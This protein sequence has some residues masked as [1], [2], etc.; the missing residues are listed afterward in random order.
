MKAEGI[1]TRKQAKGTSKQISNELNIFP[2]GKHFLNKKTELSLIK[3]RSRTKK[4]TWIRPDSVKLITTSK[5]FQN[6]EA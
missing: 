4:Y 3:N 2:V 1:E 6:D 5:T